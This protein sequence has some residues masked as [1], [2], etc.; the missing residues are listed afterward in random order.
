MAILLISPKEMYWKRYGELQA[1][2]IGSHTRSKSVCVV[3]NFIG[4]NGIMKNTP[5]TP[6]PDPVAAV[7]H[8]DPYPYYADLVKNK[9]FHYDVHLGLWVASS[10]EAV[11]AALTSDLCR[12]RPT[13][14]PVPANLLGSP[15]ADIYRHLIRMNDGEYH[16]RLKSAVKASLDQVDFIRL[17]ELSRKWAGL[18]LPPIQTQA[19]LQYY[20]FQL[21]VYVIASLLGLPDQGIPEIDRWV[22][23][24]VRCFSQISTAKQIDAGKKAAHELLDYF[25]LHIPRQRAAFPGGL[26][27]ILLQE[28]RIRGSAD[29]NAI[30]A[31]GIGFLS[32]AYEA[33][34][35]LMGNTLLALASQPI[36][37]EQILSSPDYLRLI[38]QEVLRYDPPIQNTRR[39]VEMDGMIAGE[40]VRKGETILVV[41]A[42]ANRD[43]TVNP[44]P[45]EFDI[46][47]AHYRTF[48]FGTGSHACPGKILAE[49]IAVSGIEQLL[50]SGFDPQSIVGPPVYRPSA[51]ARIPSW[52]S[53]ESSQ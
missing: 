28:A 11:T 48:A 46:H 13:Q 3:K 43:P 26:L 8:S 23:R 52:I 16:Q 21:P 17:G 18:L 47:R 37:C 19:D 51:N 5:P 25:Q 2:I 30:I 31:N 12:V 49:T 24:F 32:Q 20:V 42:A 9:P 6:P 39:F 44:N 35:G 41:L 33:T 10:A 22:S 34:A 53:Q 14:A 50:N 4:R 45:H 1:R 38:V 27:S 29:D 40:Q 36:S 7:T 15:A